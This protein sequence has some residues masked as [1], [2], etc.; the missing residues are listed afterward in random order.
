MSGVEAGVAVAVE[1]EDP[2]HLGHRR[3]LGRRHSAAPIEQRVTP[4]ALVGEAQAANGARAASQQLRR[5]DPGECAGE[6]AKD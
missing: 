2:L 3:T 5:L 6:S 4:V 1:G